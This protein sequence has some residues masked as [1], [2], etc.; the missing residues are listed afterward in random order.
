MEVSIQMEIQTL[1]FVTDKNDLDMDKMME[2]FQEF[3]M[4]N[5]ESWLDLDT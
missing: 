5:A 4:Q 3:Y 2:V 1:Q